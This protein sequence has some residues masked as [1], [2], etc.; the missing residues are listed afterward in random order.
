M[1]HRGFLISSLLMFSLLLAALGSLR[2][3]VTPLGY[4]GLWGAWAVAVTGMTWKP[5]SASWMRL[6]P[7][8]WVWGSY[9][10]L[11]MGI[12]LSAMINRS[13]ISLHHGIK[14]AVIGVCCCIAWRLVAD[15]EWRVRVLILRWAVATV[16]LVF[17]LSKA[18][19]Y[20][21]YIVMGKAGR[22]G[23]F[24]AWP[25]VI[26]KVGAFFLPLF[27]ADML[28]HRRSWMANGL[29]FAAC[30][31][32]VVIDGSRTGLL[33]LGMAILAFLVLL[34]W[35]REWSV[36]SGIKSTVAVCVPALLVLLLFSAGVGYLAHGRS[37]VHSS[38]T[39]GTV[40][41]FASETEALVGT[42]I[43]PVTKTRLGDGD[44]ERVKL[45]LN[46]IDRA[47]DCLP[48]G[49]GFGSTS[50]DPGYGVSM[51]VHNAY[52]GALADFGLLGLAGMLGFVVAAIIPIWR[53]L[54]TPQVASEDMY[55]VVAAAGSALAYLASLM[56]HTFSSEMSEWGYLILMLA[57]AWLPG[58][59]SRVSASFRV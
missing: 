1:V 31:F 48:L 45:L 6:L 32:L 12:L 46:G 50:I 3:V 22:E 33:V 8:V 51:S 35:R 13:A 57:C 27:L 20:G 40:G 29:A 30:V 43:D 14:I 26:W 16:V 47:L 4:W 42:A 23:S 39:T 44:P 9:A 10:A 36:L 19:P 38:K 21:Y 15:L 37:V 52:V 53:V 58:R 7:P 59:M 5:I 11:V 24:L 2:D 25:G 56:L 41:I 17:L 18:A 54:R 28:V 34:I 55:F 49:C